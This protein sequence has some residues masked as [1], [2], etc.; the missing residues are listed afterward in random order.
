[1]LDVSPPPHV[2]HVAH[3]SNSQVGG[4]KSERRKWIHCFEDVTTILFLVSLNGY[5]MSL[6]EDR[7]AV[8]LRNPRLSPTHPAPAV[9]NQMQDAMAIWDSICHSQWFRS[10]SIVRPARPI[11]NS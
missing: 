8:S 7:D 11:P 10:T 5:D 2:C 3:T 6:S 4:Q 9:Q 1:M